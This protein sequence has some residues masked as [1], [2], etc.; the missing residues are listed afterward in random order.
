[1]ESYITAKPFFSSI[2]CTLLYKR[3]LFLHTAHRR[4][5]QFDYKLL[6]EIL[7]EWESSPLLKN[8]FDTWKS[9]KTRDTYSSVNSF[10]I[11]S[12]NVRGFTL[13]YQEVLL[14][15]NSFTLD[16]IILIETG[17]FDYT[18]CQQ[19]FS[20][21]KLFHPK[22]ENSYGGVILL[23]RNNLKTNRVECSI[24]NICGVDIETDRNETLRVVGVYAPESKSW[25]WHDL[26]TLISRKCAFFGDFN[27]DLEKDKDKAEV[28]TLWADSH[29]LA[30]YT[31]TQS[32]SLR[33][34]RIIDYVLSAGIP[35]SIQT[36]EGGTT[37]DHKP[38]LSVLSVNSK[39][40][41]FARN[42][43]WKVFS[44]SCEYVYSFWE[45]HWYL[46]DL[47]NVYNDYISF[48]SLLI[49]RCTIFFPLNKYR[50]AIPQEL[51]MFMSYTRALSFRQKRTGDIMLKNMVITRRNTTKLFLKQFLSHRLSS[52]LATRNTNSPLSI[53]FWSRTKKYMRTP[54]ST[55]HAF[56]LP[57]NEITQ[58]PAVMC[59]AAADYYEDFFKE[60][61][62]IYHPHPYTD[63]PEVE[64]ENFDET[65]PI[66][67]LNEVLNIV[68]T[69]KKKRSC[70]AHGLSNLM[71]NALPAAYWSLLL[72][73][74]NLS[75]SKAFVPVKWKETRMLL[76]AKKDSICKP[77]LTRPISLL[78]VFLKINEKLFLDRF[79]D[80]VKRRGLLPD[81]Q[82]GF[83]ADFRLQ[84]RVLLFFE[85]VSS[86]MSN[87]LPV[88]TVFVDFKAAFDQLWFE[89]CLGKLKRMGI[90]R[91]YLCWIE[92][93]LK[94]RRAYIEIAGKKSRWF[95]I[96]KGGPQGSIF[97][98]SLFITYHADMGDFLGCCLG[99]FFAD[100]LAAVI[101]GSIGMK[102]SSQ[103][104]DLERKLQVFFENLEYYSNLTIQPI[105]YSKTEAL[106]SART[107][108]SPQIEIS[109]GNHKVE[110]V[111]EFK[112]LGY[113]IT[114]KLGFGT[115]LR[116]TMLRVRQRVGMISSVRFA[117]SSSPQLRKALFL[118]YVLP[119]FTWL[120]PLFPLFTD[121]QQNEVNDFYLTCL[122]RVLGGRYWPNNLFSYMYKE[123]TLE[124]R[125]L[126]YW[127]KYLIALSD[128][129]DGKMIFEQ[130][131]FN[132]F[133]EAWL[134]KENSI[135]GVYRSK[136]YVNHTSLLA[137][138]LSWC[139]GVSSNE[140]SINYDLEEI[141]TLVNFPAT[142]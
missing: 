140:S 133:R 8:C 118:S 125:C 50:I 100:D 16:V 77:A 47:N 13:S 81:S 12:F 44:V 21:Y 59:E 1:M 139:S 70:D 111:K 94:G 46:N 116:R 36:Y 48:T 66:A 86:L 58:D 51:K 83:R 52:L 101:A 76:L 107:I 71:F 142:F 57:N 110:W 113:W 98:P 4:L 75:L 45:K 88:A 61:T 68:H 85:Q 128:S 84:T 26:T 65:I 117:G 126:K 80:V 11:L 97:S 14:L 20:K 104:L 78:D 27:V 18:F 99:H 42:T 127:N 106:W 60:P 35:V 119:L 131:H 29:L 121:K 141:I 138:C 39:E 17:D 72:K 5:S 103:C 69:H 55:I 102:F 129:I 63:A 74:F 95:N 134:R 19:V 56:I 132:V 6:C 64:W 33:S 90:P 82:S 73:I 10:H 38:V 89:G 30:P 120:F 2:D 91:A 7:Y 136:R 34:D 123:L 67:I 40:T 92:S 124:D 62:D 41:T 31:P 22:G 43:R 9:Y 37:S 137:K 25:N 24:P 135:S 108:R 15:S 105:N 93:W 28:L 79:I 114:P 3:D 130:A 109:S 112:Y 32:T 53:S 122:K 54:S 23:V 115:L 49:A 87:S 96:M